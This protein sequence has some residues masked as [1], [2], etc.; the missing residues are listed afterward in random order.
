M[1][2]ISNIPNSLISDILRLHL[3][4]LNP[5]DAFSLWLVLG[6]KYQNI[7]PVKDGINI[8]KKFKSCFLID[9]DDNDYE[10]KEKYH[11]IVLI[12]WRNRYGCGEIRGQVINRN[13]VGLWVSQIGLCVP[14]NYKGEMHGEIIYIKRGEVFTQLRYFNGYPLYGQYDRRLI[15]YW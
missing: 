7:Y 12:K 4:R 1:E 2:S 9:P 8:S 11:N 14:F 13:P 5:R 10:I 3:K 6:K 15:D